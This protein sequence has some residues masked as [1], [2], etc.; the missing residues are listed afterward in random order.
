M[1]TSTSNLFKM[2]HA[3]AKV[4]DAVVAY[5]IRFSTA[6]KAAWANAKQ[7]LT[8]AMSTIVNTLTDKLGRVFDVYHVANRPADAGF[9]G[10]PAVCTLFTVQRPQ[11]EGQ[12]PVLAVLSTYG[13]A[14]KALEVEGASFYDLRKEGVRRLE[15]LETAR[16][17]DAYG[18]S[19]A[20]VAAFKAAANL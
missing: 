4:A 14:T 19:A 6:L 12:Q 8:C 17:Q 20:D 7:T 10:M 9:A 11:F 1:T 5:K 18:F 2:A 15:Q 16:I 3:A 13:T